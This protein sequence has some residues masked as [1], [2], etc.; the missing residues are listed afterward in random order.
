MI[1]VGLDITRLGLMVVFGQP[2]T[3]SEYIQATSRVGRDEKRPG[4]VITILN[5]HRPRDRSH[6]ERFD[7]YHRTFYRSVEAASVTPFSP[8][9]LDHGLAGTVVALARLGEPDMTPPLGAKLAADRRDRLN[10]IV[11]VLRRRVEAH[12][13]LPGDQS[14][15][16]ATTVANRVKGLLDAW[17]GIV[18]D[19]QESGIGLQYQQEVKGSQ[20]QRLLHEFLHP[21][22]ATKPPKVRKFRANRSLRDVEPNVNLWMKTLENEDL[23]PEAMEGAE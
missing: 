10:W 17:A 4:L 2:K 16:Q 20:H 15:P 9:A 7:Y 11:D 12:A 23:E 18:L 19:Y 6:F 13:N 3:T 22:I 8:R 5:L 1:S 21:E 14:E